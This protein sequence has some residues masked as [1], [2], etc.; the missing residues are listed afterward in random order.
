MNDVAPI[1][2]MSITDY[3]ITHP[4]RPLMLA[5]L[6]TL[7]AF[8]MGVA[9]VAML[10]RDSAELTRYT[11]WLTAAV[12]FLLIWAGLVAVMA[13]RRPNAEEL[14]IVWGRASR[15]IAY[16][17]QAIVVAAIWMFFPSASEIERIA[18]TGMFMLCSPSQ[19]IAAPENV[20]ANRVG[21]LASFGSLV[22][23]HALHPGGL[24]TPLALFAGA[25]GLALLFLA[26]VAPAIVDQVVSARI[27]AEETNARLQA[28][29]AEVAEE[30]DA[31]TRF[32]AAASHDLGQ[33]LQAANL[34]FSQMERAKDDQRRSQAAD[35][36]RKAFVSAEQLLSH[37]LNHLRLEADAVDPH[38]AVVPLNDSL[39][40]IAAQFAPAAEAAG[41]SITA[42]PTPMLVFT[43]RVLLDRAL[44][45]L[46]DN[47][48][49]H[50][51]A[52]RL[53]LGARRAGPGRIRLWVIDDGVGIGQSEASRVFDDYFR[54][55]DSVSATASGF[56][57]GL[58]S[59]RRI[60]ALLGGSAGIDPRYHGGA[61]F[62]LELAAMTAA[63]AAS[64]PRRARARKGD[65]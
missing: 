37:M 42:M 58:S 10:V 49:R 7:I 46:V 13:A 45:N 44:S 6:V 57:L 60:A 62:Y 16:V 2:D 47:A 53:L 23:W 9:A 3:A 8:A 31:K 4:L 26:G 32:I 52:K 11:I 54:G 5:G 27:E 51:G 48:I 22:V 61:A 24:T 40:R 65:V 12:L 14:V 25:N 43:D 38:M 34:F 15:F 63:Q 55:S 17:S 56:G 28:A 39:R 36:V 19:I 64:S 21:V 20:T 29:L 59:V 1:P 41:I 33:P 35:G 18:L 30:R 50:S